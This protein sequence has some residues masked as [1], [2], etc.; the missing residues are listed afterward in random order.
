MTTSSP[1]ALE[2]IDDVRVLD[3]HVWTLGGSV[4]SCVVTLGTATPRDPDTYRA[5][6]A[7]FGLAHLTIEVQ[8]RVDVEADL[9]S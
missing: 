2:G 4:K 5:G 3:L 6:L 1:P 9:A 8:R 7:S